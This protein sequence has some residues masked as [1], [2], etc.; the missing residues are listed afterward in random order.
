MLETATPYRVLSER[1]TELLDLRTPPVAVQ[2]AAA[3][4]AGVPRAERDLKGCMYLDTARFDRRVF[5]VDHDNLA[6]CPGGRYYMGMGEPFA[7]LLDGTF[8]SGEFPAEG[9]AVFGNPQAVRETLKD[10][11]ILP[12]GQASVVCYGPLDLVA[13]D[14]ADGPVVIN[15]FCPAKTGMFLARAITYESGGIVNGPI[16]PPTCSSAMVQ[17][18]MTGEAVY[19]LGCFG[20]RRYVR[21]GIDEIVIGLPLALLASTVANLERLYARRPDIA[22]ALPLNEAVE[23]PMPLTAATP[24]GGLYQ[25]MFPENPENA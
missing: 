7:R 15:V 13:F 5:H 21:I 1:L 10:Y 19:T 22:S 18:A 17:P 11:A 4:P 16:G 9:L 25:R 3:P 14:P 23:R 24:L 6:P 12:K 20:F 2:F 8:P